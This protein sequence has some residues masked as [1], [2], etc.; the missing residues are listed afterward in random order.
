[1]NQFNNSKREP[2]P[3]QAENKVSF[4]SVKRGVNKHGSPTL[5]L[6]LGTEDCAKLAELLEA[7]CNADNA[8][9]AKIMV[10]II[11]GANYDSGYAYINPKVPQELQNSS[12]G[13][14]NNDQQNSR[15]QR[16]SGY[17]RTNKINQRQAFKSQGQAASKEFFKKKKLNNKKYNF[18]YK[19]T[20]VKTYEDII[21]PEKIH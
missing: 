21:A 15:N 12:G 6:Y 14:A 7:A 9:G 13:E 5:G 3:L 17:S 4:S 10:Q 16:N 1:M 18:E 20:N 19:T 11:E 8:T 2:T